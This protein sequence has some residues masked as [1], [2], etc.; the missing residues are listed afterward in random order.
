LP[1]ENSSV[2][3]T[4]GSSLTAMRYEAVAN[5]GPAALRGMKIYKE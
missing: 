1:G 4:D 2:R 3:V 5:T